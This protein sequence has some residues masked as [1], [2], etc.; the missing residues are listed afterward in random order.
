M[1]DL[2]SRYRRHGESLLI[3]MKLNTLAQLFNSLDPSPFF[4]KDLDQD[5]EPGHQGGV[6]GGLPEH[7]I[8]RQVGDVAQTVELE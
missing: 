1:K 7:R 3:E 8:G 4:E 6:D 5:A 2:V